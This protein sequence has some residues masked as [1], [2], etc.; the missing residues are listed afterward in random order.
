MRK[1]KIEDSSL[2]A[3]RPDWQFGIKTEDHV[4][5][6]HFIK[7]MSIVQKQVLTE[8]YLNMDMVVQR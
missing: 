8:D 3:V 7:G 1:K 2:P 6:H 5:P 4:D